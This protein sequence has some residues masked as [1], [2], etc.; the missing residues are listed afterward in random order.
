MYF[1]STVFKGGVVR[2]EDI[3]AIMLSGD[4]SDAFELVDTTNVPGHL[5]CVYESAGMD[6]CHLIYARAGD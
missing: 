2:I 5:L 1:I 3:E 6:Y 4:R